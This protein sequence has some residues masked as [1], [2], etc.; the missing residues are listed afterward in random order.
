MQAG[1]LRYKDDHR[2]PQSAWQCRVHRRCHLWH[3][4]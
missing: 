3:C 1:R 4:L 2:S